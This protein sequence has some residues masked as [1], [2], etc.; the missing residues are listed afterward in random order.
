MNVKLQL[1]YLVFLLDFW[2]RQLIALDILALPLPRS[3]KVPLRGRRNFSYR[4][5]ESQES[6]YQAIQ[7][8]LRVQRSVAKLKRLHTVLFQTRFCN[9]A[10]HFSL[11]AQPSIYNAAN[12][13]N[14]KV[15]SLGH[16]QTKQ[17][18]FFC[19]NKLARENQP[20]VQKYIF[21]EKK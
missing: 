8:S 3:E 5:T 1:V 10:I 9:F 17:R 19:S 14:T 2:N 21:I 16:M 12:S 4:E 6:K 11:L 7:G 20:K 15:R 18:K 13:E